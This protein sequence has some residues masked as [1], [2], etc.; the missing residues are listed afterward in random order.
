MID[1]P[2]GRLTEPRVELRFG[3]RSDRGMVRLHN[4][5]SYITAPPASSWLT[6]W[7]GMPRSG[8]VAGCRREFP[9]PDRPQVGDR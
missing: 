9:L 8:R 3:A 4:E 6:V 1:T 7:A 2:H 5:D